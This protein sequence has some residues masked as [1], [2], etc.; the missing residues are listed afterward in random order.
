MTPSVLRRMQVTSSLDLSLYTEIPGTSVAAL[1]G[2]GGVGKSAPLGD[3]VWEI[4]RV[5][6]LG[7]GCGGARFM[8]E[9]R[10]VSTVRPEGNQ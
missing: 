5:L 2:G 1:F 8:Q 7:A 3:G 9:T 10:L 6:D 4:F